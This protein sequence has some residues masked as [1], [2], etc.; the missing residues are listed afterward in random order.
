MILLDVLRV[1]FSVISVPFLEISSTVRFVLKSLIRFKT[2]GSFGGI[3]ESVHWNESF[4][5]IHGARALSQ[6]TTGIFCAR[7]L[8]DQRLGQTARGTLAPSAFIIETLGFFSIACLNLKFLF[9]RGFGLD[10]LRSACEVTLHQTLTFVF[11][12][13]EWIT[14]EL[15]CFS[16][17]VMVP[18]CEWL[19]LCGKIALRL[20]NKASEIIIARFILQTHLLMMLLLCCLAA[21]K[22][23]A[24]SIIFICILFKCCL[25]SLHQSP[26]K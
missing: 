8:K 12:S 14:R 13:R 24:P 11:G 20:L 16:F 9:L 26:V 5:S 25:A 19:E 23:L 21:C 4:M 22:C 10:T 7:A 15:A 1:S 3:Q 17:E 2:R 18:P 6:H